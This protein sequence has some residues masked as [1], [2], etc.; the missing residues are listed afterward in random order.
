MQSLICAIIFRVKIFSPIAASLIFCLFGLL[1]MQSGFASSQ[2]ALSN[3]VYTHES[4]QINII[5]V[6]SSSKLPLKNEVAKLYELQGFDLIWSDGS[7]YNENAR[8]LL[9]IIQQAKNYGLSSLDYDLDFIQ[10]FLDATSVDPKLLSRSD[11]AFTHAYIKLAS[12]VN[13]GKSNGTQSISDQD[14]TLLSTLSDAVDKHAVRPTIDKL[15]P[16]RSDYVNL[17]KA[18]GQYRSIP[19]DQPQLQLSTRSLAMGDRAI[20]VADLRKKLHLLG[21]YIGDDLSSDLFD[22]SLAV[23]VSHFQIRHGLEADGVLGKQTVRELNTPITR[24]I[25]QLEINLERARRLSAIDNDRYLL[26]NIPAFQLY[27]YENEQVAYQSRV[28]VGKKKHKTPLLS[29]ELTN[30]VLSPYWHVPRS[31]TTKEIIPAIQKDPQYLA[32][33]NMKLFGRLNNQTYQVNPTTID[34]SAINPA[35][36]NFRVRQDP[37]VKNS[38]GQIKFIFPNKYSVYLHDTPAR[39]LFAEPRRAFSHG[40][41]RLE[42]PFALAEVL[43]SSGDSAYSKSDLLYLAKRNKAKSVKLKNPIPIHITYMTAWA[44]EHGVVHFRPDI[45][46]RDSQ[47]AANLYNAQN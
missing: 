27:L 44:D 13:H 36:A 12:H 31:I 10:Y 17:V 9:E 40:C 41:I 18:L 3:A 26:I 43:L 22:E 14:S 7:R 34:W 5:N 47:F 46:K 30:I 16:S 23:A 42:D 37:G 29:S 11:V 35:N 19:A 28:I 21:D 15:Q 1:S 45:Y 39:N 8:Q 4:P 32:K 25:E 38:L 20:E 33:N 2:Y 6:L 24:R